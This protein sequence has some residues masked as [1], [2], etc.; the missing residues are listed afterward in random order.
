LAR[1]SLLRHA[2]PRN[3]RGIPFFN[4]SS[5]I[6]TK[7]SPTTSGCTKKLRPSSHSPTGAS[8]PTRPAPLGE[9]KFLLHVI[10]IAQ[11]KMIA[12]VKDDLVALNLETGNLSG[13][14]A[15]MPKA[16][17]AYLL[18]EVNAK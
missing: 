3:E 15:A 8:S 1:P 9:P 11:T 16:P 6:L 17:P 2:S 10:Q 4:L 7:Q 14:R 13:R 5:V 18:Q 12:Q